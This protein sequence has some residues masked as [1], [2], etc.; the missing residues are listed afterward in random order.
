MRA[1]S[2]KPGYSEVSGLRCRPCTQRW[3]EGVV[4][5]P[6]GQRRLVIALPYL[7][8]QCGEGWGKLTPRMAGSLKWN[9]AQVSGRNRG[10][11]KSECVIG[12]V[13]VAL[14]VT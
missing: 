4:K 11:R 12:R 14:D 2:N 10:P 5:L 9:P 1:R 8:S 7:A 3:E 13:S 6:P